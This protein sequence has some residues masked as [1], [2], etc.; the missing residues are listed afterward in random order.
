MVLLVCR[1][2]L[3]FGADEKAVGQVV[4]LV[5]RDIGLL[6]DVSVESNVPAAICPIPIGPRVGSVTGRGLGL[7]DNIREIQDLC[8]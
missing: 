1:E 3:D 2:I 6:E 8:R 5:L 4:E 7:G